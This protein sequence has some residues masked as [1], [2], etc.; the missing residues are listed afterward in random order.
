MEIRGTVESAAPVPPRSAQVLLR[1][2]GHP[3]RHPQFQES[4][5]QARGR[6][7]AHILLSTQQSWPDSLKAPHARAL[8][9]EKGVGWYRIRHSQILQADGRELKDYPGPHT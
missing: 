4:P 2:K 7:V 3:S 9:E 8:C 5:S 1:G 6:I